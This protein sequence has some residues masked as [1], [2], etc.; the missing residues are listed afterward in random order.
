MRPLKIVEDDYRPNHAAETRKEL[1]I[2]TVGAVLFAGSFFM[3][4]MLGFKP[5]LAGFPG[6]RLTAAGNVRSSLHSLFEG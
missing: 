3:V 6:E 5:A 1:V 4:Y 2:F